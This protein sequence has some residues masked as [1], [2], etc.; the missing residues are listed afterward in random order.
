MGS[1]G[2]PTP[3]AQSGGHSRKRFQPHVMPGTIGGPSSSSPLRLGWVCRHDGVAAPVPRSRRAAQASPG[4]RLADPRGVPTSARRRRPP[5]A[6]PSRPGRARQARAAH[7]RPH[8]PTALRALR[9][10]LARPRPRRPQA[11]P[12]RP[13]QEGRQAAPPAHPFEPRASASAVANARYPEPT[14]PVFCG[15]QGGRLQE[16]ILADII[17]RAAK[18]AGLE[19]HVTAHTLRHTAATWLRQKLGD[20]LLVAEY[21]GHADLST[22]AR[23]AHVDRKELFEAA[24][25]LE[26]LANQ[27]DEAAEPPAP[28][29][30][31]NKAPRPTEPG[32][33]PRRRR[34]PRRRGRR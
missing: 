11:V 31:C 25:C 8:G 6:E 5:E 4:A 23:Y 21:L 18:R 30:Q 29:P 28:R 20:T 10:R 12:A 34:R 1:E 7:P 27:T 3:I 9:P 14:D 19:K 32:Q 17:G 2:T 33:P 15:L 24:G 26:Q 22:V 16:T 13:L